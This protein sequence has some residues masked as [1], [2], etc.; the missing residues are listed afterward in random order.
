M[1]KRYIIIALSI[2]IFSAS[3]SKKYEESLTLYKNGNT[4]KAREIW[5]EL[6]KEKPKKLMPDILFLLGSTEPDYFSAILYYR[7]IIQQY[8]KYEKIDKAIMK[9]GDLYYLHSNYTEAMRTYSII[10]GKYP[11]SKYSAEAYYWL[12]NIYLDKRKYNKAIEYYNKVLYSKTYNDMV[13]LANLGIAYAHY[14]MQKYEVAINQ[15]KKIKELFPYAE[16]MINVYIGLGDSYFR[17][18]KYKEAYINYKK[19]LEKYPDTPQATIAE[20][21]LKHIK[22]RKPFVSSSIEKNPDIINKNFTIQVGSFKNKSNANNLRIKMKKNGFDSFVVEFKKGD[23]IMYRT[24]V[25]RFAEKRDALETKDKIK[26]TIKMD[27]FIIEL[28]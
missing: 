7:Q 14:E 11:E 15:Y 13:P 10:I 23:T 12:G 28:E 5:I 24:V 6:K 3:T 21:Q 22:R 25:G 26:E 18:K 16:I 4:E 9:L 1:N 8:S 2:F 17:L 20:N 27:S 19:V